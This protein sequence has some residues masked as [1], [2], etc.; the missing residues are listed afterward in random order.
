MPVI[1]SNT[2]QKF[3]SQQGL[4][5]IETVLSIALAVIVITSLVSL[6]LFTL[7]SSTQNKLMLQSS[8]LA[9]QQ[10][11]LVRACRDASASWADF[12]TTLGNCIAV[13]GTE[14]SIV[15]AAGGSQCGTA[16]IYVTTA[17]TT[18]GSGL[19]E[20]DHYFVLEDFN[21]NTDE[22]KVSVTVQWLIGDETKTAHTYSLITNW[23]N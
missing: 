9:D 2:G 18:T 1:L 20:V 12:R 23:V 19:E 16:N 17:R 6:S 13:P 8:K 4:G 15:T 10:L 7:R 14:C 5:L 3:S 11:E 21:G 22:I